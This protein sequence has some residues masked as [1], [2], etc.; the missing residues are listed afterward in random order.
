MVLIQSSN[1]PK[2]QIIMFGIIIVWEGRGTLP[3]MLIIMII[4]MIIIIV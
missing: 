2:K 3:G 1:Y 4:M